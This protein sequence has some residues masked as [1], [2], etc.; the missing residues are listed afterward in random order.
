MGPL[1]LGIAVVGG[2]AWY[3]LKPAAPPAAPATP[4]LPA[5][6]PVLNPVALN[7]PPPM[8]QDDLV[9]ATANLSAL[10]DPANMV[11]VEYEGTAWLV[12]PQYVGPV[13]IGQAYQIATSLGLSLPTPGLVDAIWRAADLHIVPPVRASD[14]TPATMSTPAV[15]AAQKA[16]ID[17]LVGG[18]A[19]SL[20]AGTHKDIVMGDAKSFA[21]PGGNGLKAGK[22]GLYG[23]HSEVPIAG[24]ALH[25]PSTPGPGAVIQQP[26]GGHGL[27]WQDYSQGLRLVRK[28]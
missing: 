3:L 10:A 2:L 18:R 17:A 4:L 11:P 15:Y 14:G 26:F 5:A 9:L 8:S 20:L 27:D 13:G 6:D 23:W 28:A 1:I 7:V 12:S 16:R 22:P 21:S 24:V 19:F 25:A